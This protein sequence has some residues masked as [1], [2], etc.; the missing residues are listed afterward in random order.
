MR[1]TGCGQAKQVAIVGENDTSI[2]DGECD[3]LF[4]ARAYQ[5]R[6]GCSRDVDLATAKS[7]GDHVR[8][9]FVEVKSR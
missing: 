1:H 3:M 5:T 6:V 2:A 8:D 4:I 9:V 7:V